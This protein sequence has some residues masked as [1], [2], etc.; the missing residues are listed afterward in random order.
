MRKL[1]ILPLLTLAFCS[2]AQ[3]DTAYLP[4]FVYLTYDT[5][6]WAIEQTESERYASVHLN[7]KLEKGFELDIE[8]NI[9][10]TIITKENLIADLER[11]TPYG[12]EMELQSLDEMGEYYIGVFSYTQDECSRNEIPAIFK[13]MM[14]RTA[15]RIIENTNLLTIQVDHDS[16]FFP[17]DLQI[18]KIKELIKS[19][20]VVTP[21]QIDQ[22]I[23]YP[24]N[25]ERTTAIVQKTYDSAYKSS[26]DFNLS[27]RQCFDDSYFLSELSEF[28]EYNEIDSILNFA[29]DSAICHLVANYHAT[30]VSMDKS[31]QLEYKSTIGF[32]YTE[33]TELLRKANNQ[34]FSLEEYLDFQLGLAKEGPIA[35]LKAYSNENYNS[36]EKEKYIGIIKKLFA[37][38][39]NEGKYISDLNIQELGNQKYLIKVFASKNDSI[40]QMRFFHLEKMDNIFYVNEIQLPSEFGIITYKFN[41]RL[42]TTDSGFYS[43]EVMELFMRHLKTDINISPSPQK[44]LIAFYDKKYKSDDFPAYFCIGNSKD[45]KWIP[46][47]AASFDSSKYILIINNLH[48]GYDDYI[49]DNS[50]L[51]WEKF[52]NT[53]EKKRLNELFL[54]RYN[55]SIDSAIALFN[56]P[57]NSYGYDYSI[58]EYEI[59]IFIEQNT[60]V[61]FIAHKFE[62][63]GDIQMDGYE[64]LYS[65]VISNGKIIDAKA[66]LIKENSFELIGSKKVLKLFQMNTGFQNLI[67][68]SQIGNHGTKEIRSKSDLYNVLQQ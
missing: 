46:T 42:N 2:A 43:D 64:D 29:S 52:E 22:L 17:E 32:N 24:L 38:K 21:A 44:Q 58:S 49:E 12:R 1:L 13:S 41:N 8:L 63:T 68:S 53:S 18:N 35:R 50:T 39:Y 26:F 20:E 66:Y 56:D 25:S 34:A 36:S 54:A 27:K 7:G 55:T 48:Q 6:E 57:S 14:F 37:E 67:F 62:G 47:T 19:I 45:I 59:R 23:G 4:P 10:D 31:Y 65:L 30:N 5:K 40:T 51:L 15:F 60:S 11:L 33:R 16:F 9:G 3:I 28:L 61:N